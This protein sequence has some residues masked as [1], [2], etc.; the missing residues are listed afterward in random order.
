M[1]EDLLP[2]IFKPL[3]L[4]Q[5]IKFRQLRD[6]DFVPA[7]IT[8]LCEEI[9]GQHDWWQYQLLSISAISKR[10]GLIVEGLRFWFKQ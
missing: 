8:W 3:V 4:R 7:D 10:Y 1:A 2:T 6:H 9:D 5:R